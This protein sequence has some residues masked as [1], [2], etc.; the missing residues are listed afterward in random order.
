[1]F[2]FR[3]RE[4]LE[5]KGFIWVQIEK[6]IFLYFSTLEDLFRFYKISQSIQKLLIFHRL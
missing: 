5:I 4:L 1:M 6:P 3:Y 2:E